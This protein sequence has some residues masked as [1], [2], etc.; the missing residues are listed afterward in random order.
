MIELHESSAVEAYD[1][2][3]RTQHLTVRTKWGK[4]YQ[5]DDVPQ[6]VIDQFLKAKSKGHYFHH[7]IRKFYSDNSEKTETDSPLRP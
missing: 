6:F 3:V 4:E 1:Y 7:M 2:D 5:F